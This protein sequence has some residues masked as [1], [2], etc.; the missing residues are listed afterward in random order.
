MKIAE[1]ILNENNLQ[2]TYWGD[3][4]IKAEE[5][6]YF[7][8]TDAKKAGSWTTCACGKQD[9]RIPRHDDGDPVDA[10]LSGYGSRFM[11]DVIN[12]HFFDAASTLIAIEKRAVVL[13][14]A[15]IVNQ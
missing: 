3:R 4:I 14:D 7:T 9:P 5:R 13:L 12:N 1:K 10:Y 2:Y 6:G 15:L 8:L 11:S